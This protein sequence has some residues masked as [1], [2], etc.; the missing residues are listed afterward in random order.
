MSQCPQ[1][2][3]KDSQDCHWCLCSI[4]LEAPGWAARPPCNAP[5]CPSGYTSLDT[6]T[7]DTTVLPEGIVMGERQPDHELSPQ[8]EPVVVPV[9]PPVEWRAVIIRRVL[10]A[11]AA[12]AVLLVGI[13]VRLLTGNG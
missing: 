6:D 2:L 12:I 5:L 4:S 13:L 1:A 10:A 7:G 11:A 8:E 9:L 3:G